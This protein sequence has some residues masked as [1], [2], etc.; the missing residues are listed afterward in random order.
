MAIMV[1]YPDNTYEKVS[2]DLLDE[3]IDAG[4]IVA[5]RR[6]SGW[7]EIGKDPVR[8]KTAPAGYAGAERR[9]SAPGRNCLTCPEFVGSNC[10][11]DTCS[12]RTSLQGK[13]Y[14][15]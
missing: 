15:I 4:R 3:L 14:R 2:E 5:F 10:T 11:S 12:N 7:A 8:S 9:A 1:Q 13:S 6:A